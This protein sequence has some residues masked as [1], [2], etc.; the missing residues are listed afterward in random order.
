MKIYFTLIFTLIIYSLNA[1]ASAK[2]S[3]ALKLMKDGELAKAIVLADA[4]VKEDEG[5]AE[6]WYARGLVRLESNNSSGALEDFVK[7]EILK[8]NS[9]DLLLNKSTYL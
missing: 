5:D 4:A 3:E 6:N 7:A 2:R 1:Q 9:T 8:M